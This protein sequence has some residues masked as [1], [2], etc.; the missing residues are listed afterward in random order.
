M[1][2]Q[3]MKNEVEEQG[4]SIVKN[5]ISQEEVARYRAA[6]EKAMA[7]DMEEFN[8]LPQKVDNHIVDMVNRDPLFAKYLE[9]DNLYKIFHTFLGDYFTVYSFT[10]SILRPGEKPAA[11]EIHI[12]SKKFPNI[13]GYH[14]G[15]LVTMSLDD[16]TEE[17]G[18]TYYL[19]GSQKRTDRPSEEEFYANAVRVT[20]E[21]GDVVVFNP[22]VWHAAG[23]NN[24]DKT[25]Y[26]MTAYM[27]R[28]FIKQRLDY[29]RM[30]KPEVFDALSD[31]GKAILGFTSQVPSSL[32]EYYV[33]AEERLYKDTMKVS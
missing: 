18:A 25:R 5:V 29:P 3:K 1:D 13:P 30:T 12:D 28:S 32:E 4:F 23:Q 8:H 7:D 19:P 10:S 11:A 14:F 15:L 26:A 22:L 21:A 27:C 9:T 24:T 16:F 6:L 31:R 33:P 2:L 20:R 17:N